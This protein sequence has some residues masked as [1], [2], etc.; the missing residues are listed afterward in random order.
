MTRPALE[1]TQ[2]EP[3]S[4]TIAVEL[5]SL[6]RMLRSYQCQSNVS[7]SPVIFIERFYCSNGDD[8]FGFVFKFVEH[9]ISTVHMIFCS[10]VNVNQYKYMQIN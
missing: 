5:C 7:N 6:L 4:D 9:K 2:N 10:I 1:Q 8:N 3:T